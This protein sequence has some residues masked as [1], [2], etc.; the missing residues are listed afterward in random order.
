VSHGADSD[1]ISDLVQLGKSG[2]SITKVQALA[3]KTIKALGGS[4]ACL[5]EKIVRSDSKSFS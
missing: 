3:A 1:H 4:W 2:E 5:S